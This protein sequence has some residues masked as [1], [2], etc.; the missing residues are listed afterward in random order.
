VIVAVLAMLTMHVPGDDVIDVSGV[1]NR[2]VLAAD[3]VHVIDRMRIARVVRIAAREIVFSEFVLVDVIAVRMV[4]MPV[5][6]VI[7][8][9]FMANGE[10]AACGTVKVIVAIVNVRFHVRTSG[11][12]R[13]GTCKCTTGALRRATGTRAIKREV[14]AARLETARQLG[15]HAGTPFEL[16]DAFARRTREMVV[17]P[18]TRDFVK[19]AAAGN[20]DDG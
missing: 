9:I 8:V 11:N 13:R 12:L 2:D 4:E 16:V 20:L 5:V 10:M 19:R 7:D 6:H 18:L 14:V 17:V 1:R 15:A 3:A